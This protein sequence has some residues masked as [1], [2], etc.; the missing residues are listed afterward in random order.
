MSIDLIS[1]VIMDQNIMYHDFI[2]IRT[3]DLMRLHNNIILNKNIIDNNILDQYYSFINQTALFSN[4]RYNLDN[5][6]LFTLNDG[7]IRS[8]TPMINHV[9]IKGIK[10]ECILILSNR[11]YTKYV[12]FCILTI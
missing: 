12:K 2:K 7:W 9:K 10:S 4:Y 8:K 11:Q 3:I 6:D 1:D 5:Y